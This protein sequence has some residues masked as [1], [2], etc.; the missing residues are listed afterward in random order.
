VARQR[1][2]ELARILGR[3]FEGSAHSLLANI[4]TVTEKEWEALPPGA[5]RSLREIVGHV[6]MFKYIYANHGFRDGSMDY[7]DAPATPPLERLASPAAATDWLREAH[8]YLMEAVAE[9]PDDRELD[10]PRK[11][12]WGQMVPTLLLIDITHEHDIYHAGEINRTRG[13]LQGNDGW[14]VPS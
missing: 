4:G 5:Q 2:D 3:S 9:L 14:F 7:G 10:R 11:A 12:H 6:G 8:A 13:M 1:I